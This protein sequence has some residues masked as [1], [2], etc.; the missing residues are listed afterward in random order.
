MGLDVQQDSGQLRS[1]ASEIEMWAKQLQQNT[2]LIEDAMNNRLGAEPSGAYFWHGPNAQKFLD[3]FNNK[4]PE[5]F[6]NAYDNI[7]SM[8]TNLESQA[9]RW[10]SFESQ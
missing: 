3:D 7:V 4:Y 8:A 9:E 6:K 2:K 10:E 1:I 5:K